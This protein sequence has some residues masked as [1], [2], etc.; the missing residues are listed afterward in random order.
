MEGSVWLRGASWRAVFG[1]EERRVLEGR[2]WLRG[3][4][5][6]AVFGLEVRLGGW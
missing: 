5:W 3:M 2:D 1:L 6:R 4:S